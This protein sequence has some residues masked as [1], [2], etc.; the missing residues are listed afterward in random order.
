LQ[1]RA[2]E[3]GESLDQ[4]I[5]RP[6]LPVVEADGLSQGWSLCFHR[7]SL[8]SGTRLDGG[9]KVRRKRRK[10]SLE[11]PGIQPRNGKRPDAAAR[12]AFPAG[13]RIQQRGTAAV[14]PVTGLPKDGKR[15]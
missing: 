7:S 1:R 8:C 5:N 2:G 15:E 14:K 13:E 12:A 3:L 10:S 9:T 4:F 11:L 6:V